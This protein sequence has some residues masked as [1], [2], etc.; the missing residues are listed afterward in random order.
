MEDGIAELIGTHIEG[1]G[2]VQQR[3]ADGESGR[4]KDGW[5]NDELHTAFV[6]IGE[7]RMAL[8]A[9]KSIVQT[10]SDREQ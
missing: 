8:D 9:A 10:K 4:S 7:A 5:I 2:T 3:L 6:L 1:L